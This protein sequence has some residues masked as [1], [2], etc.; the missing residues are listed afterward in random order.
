M[1]PQKGKVCGIDVHKK[2]VVAAVLSNSGE[3]WIERFAQTQPGLLALKSWVLD[4]GCEQVAVE[5]TG[6]YWYSVYS[7]LEG[8]IE[9]IVANPYRIKN[10]PGRKTDI[11]DAQWIAELALNSL[12]K[13]S[14]IFPKEDR[15][16]RNLTR[17]RENQV[18]SRTRLKNRIHRVLESASI[19]LSS[20]ITDIFGTS[21]QYILQQILQGTSIDTIIQGIPSQKVKEKADALK[22]AIQHHLGDDQVLIIEQSLDQIGLI[23]QQI[24]DLDAEIQTRLEERKEE[25][26]IAM[27]VPGIGF[28]SAATI[29]AEIGNSQDFASADKLASW[30]G[31]TPAVYQSADTLRTGRITKTGSK[32]LRWI[33]VEVAQAA[34]RKK[35]SVLRTFFLRLK[36]RKGYTV[37]IVALARKILCILWHLLTN[38]EYYAEENIPAKR[39]KMPRL[40]D[41]THKTIEQMIEILVQAGY[42]VQKRGLF[43]P[44]G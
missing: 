23:N 13:P 9:V 3:V 4:H 33:L 17:A 7:T 21:G 10:I 16:L 34:A 2:F 36:A 42:V 24:L 12:I 38:R 26:R 30:A 44:G 20:V 15:E 22:D 28:I 32:H 35:N 1:L 31:L 37:A 5:S 41:R 6:V 27:S 14:R 40:I 43:D 39:G 29:L 18:H 19:K 8:R 11:V 25:L